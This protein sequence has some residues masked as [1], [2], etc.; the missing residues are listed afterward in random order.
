V[1]EFPYEITITAVY[2]PPQHNLKKKEHFEI[3]FQ[4]LGPKF[5]A[6]VD[7]NSKRTLSGSCLTTTKDRE[8]SK[9]I[10]EKNYSFLSTGTPTYWREQNPGSTR[11]LCNQWNLL[12]IHR[13]TIKLR[14]N[15]G[16]FSNNSNIKHI[17]Y[18]QKTN[19]TLA[20]LKN[21]LG[22]LQTNNTGQSKSINK[23]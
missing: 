15:L 7:Y 4:T 23:T 16:P 11:S 21:K 6:G 1:K 3:F 22:Y 5:I 12:N 13:H 2:C 8:L 19:T 20:Q 14:L 18:S 10:Q 17:N 9:V